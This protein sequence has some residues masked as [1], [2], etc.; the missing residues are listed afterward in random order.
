[1]QDLIFEISNNGLIIPQYMLFVNKFPQKNNF[2]QKNIAKF[3]YRHRHIKILKSKNPQ[4]E[5]CG[6]FIKVMKFR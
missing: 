4:T 3:T 5:V 6:F 1:M 2:F